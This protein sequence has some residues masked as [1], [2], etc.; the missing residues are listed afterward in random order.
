[1][2]APTRQGKGR[3]ERA[4]VLCTTALT[5]VGLAAA[6]GFPGTAV[7]VAPSTG[8]VAGPPNEEVFVDRLREGGVPAWAI[9]CAAGLLA[10]RDSPWVETG[11]VTRNGRF[12]ST[13][14][15]LIVPN[16]MLKEGW[17]KNAPPPLALGQIVAVDHEWL[18]VVAT[19]LGK[20]T[21]RRAI[22]GT[23]REQHRDNRQL[24]RLTELAALDAEIDLVAGAIIAL[25]EPRGAI[26]LYDMYY[27]DVGSGT[28]PRFRTPA[29]A[30]LKAQAY[31]LL[32]WHLV[33]P[34]PGT[35]LPGT[36]TS[37]VTLFD[38]AGLNLARAKFTLEG[39][40]DDLFKGSVPTSGAP[41]RETLG[42]WMT[43]GV[44]KP[45]TLDEVR[46]GSFMRSP[47]P[48]EQALEFARSYLEWQSRISRELGDLVYRATGGAAS[49]RPVPGGASQTALAYYADA[50]ASLYLARLLSPDDK[51]LLAEARVL[52]DRI[53]WSRVGLGFGGSDFFALPPYRLDT[54]FTMA[55][56][57][58]TSVVNM[59][60]EEEKGNARDMAKQETW[61]TELV[62]AKNTQQQLEN[63]FRAQ[64]RRQLTASVVEIEAKLSEI[65]TEET[66]FEYMRARDEVR[67]QIE[68]GQLSLQG[69]QYRG[70]LDRLHAQRLA[71]FLAMLQ[72]LERHGIPSGVLETGK[73]S[74]PLPA[75]L[76]ELGTFANGIS[77]DFVSKTAQAIRNEWQSVLALRNKPIGDQSTT[78]ALRHLECKAAEM[79]AGR[80]RDRLLVFDSKARLPELIAQQDAL[81]TR[82]DKL[83]NELSSVWRDLD[84][85]KRGDVEKAVEL[86]RR[87]QIIPRLKSQ[88]KEFTGRLHQ[89][90]DKV[91][92]IQNRLQQVRKTVED[93]KEARKKVEDAY[94]EVVGIVKAAKAIPVTV[95]AGMTT[96][97]FF[98]TGEAIAKGTQAVLD[99][100]VAGFQ[101]VDLAL[102]L[103]QAIDHAADEVDKYLKK[104]E[105]V[106]TQL[107]KAQA[108][109]EN[110]STV[111]DAIRP[112]DPG[113]PQYNETL[114]KEREL[115][116]NLERLNAKLANL[117]SEIAS[118]KVVI[119]T[120]ERRDLEAWSDRA[121][122]LARAAL[123][124]FEMTRVESDHRV[125][126]LLAQAEKI[127][128]INE[129]RSN[130]EA[131]IAFYQK[132]VDVASLRLKSAIRSI[133]K[134]DA[135]RKEA[136]LAL[137]LRLVSFRAELDELARPRSRVVTGELIRSLAPALALADTR[138][139]PGDI[140]RM[141]DRGNKLALQCARWL[142]VFGGDPESILLG[143]PARSPAEL[144]LMTEDLRSRWDR[145]TGYYRRSPTLFELKLDTDHL[146]QLGD[147]VVIRVVVAPGVREVGEADPFVAGKKSPVLIRRFA[148]STIDRGI[149]TF[150]VAG[151]DWD[152]A[153]LLGFWVLHRG[154]VNL[155]PVIAP[156]GPIRRR[157]PGGAAL[158]F[159]IKP[160][161]VVVFNP[162]A[163]ADLYNGKNVQDY[164]EKNQQLPPGRNFLADP[165]PAWQPA[166]PNSHFFGHGI[167]GLWAMQVEGTQ[168]GDALPL[169]QLGEARLVFA[170]L[171]PNAQPRTPNNAGE[172][173]PPAPDLSFLHRSPAAVAATEDRD[174]AFFKDDWVHSPAARSARLRD[175]AALLD[176]DLKNDPAE[177]AIPEPPG[178]SE[179]ARAFEAELDA[180]FKSVRREAGKGPDKI[181][182]IL[183]PLP[184]AEQIAQA[185]TLL[186]RLTAALERDY[187]SRVVTAARVLTRASARVEQVEAFTQDLVIQNDRFASL[188][189]YADGLA[190]LARAVDGR[191]PHDDPSVADLR[192]MADDNRWRARLAGALAKEL[193]GEKDGRSVI[194]IDVL[195]HLTRRSVSPRTEAS[196]MPPASPTPATPRP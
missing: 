64:A 127:R 140:Q 39:V 83:S 186:D 171:P 172:L 150:Q 41:G 63:A 65:T 54:Y 38:A 51:A 174:R 126:L 135:K 145:L 131:L 112:Y 175:L 60:R 22:G 168:A 49:T 139:K 68:R 161:P 110:E 43:R 24:R 55:L 162:K 18:E 189:R 121:N 61:L 26:T 91:R 156:V 75:T 2:G 176:D 95:T 30:L 132:S 16:E 67:E 134:D 160:D 185:S 57:E 69:T 72:D 178:E 56:M 119:T 106:E 115:N 71:E 13:A 192:A 25:G 92:D 27:N 62:N 104:A 138:P 165:F 34:P 141:L 133:D 182:T 96:G 120:A 147:R 17:T 163:E 180:V 74:A 102:K 108:D 116:A 3:A 170:I 144:K 77:S 53:A 87:R 88:I 47:L 183:L 36:V 173:P 184:V 153:A 89:A 8:E 196:P 73:P 142:Y 5:L 70:E 188:A 66:R 97:T 107:R 113:G 193:R 125:A 14:D 6:I 195:E 164:L 100:I 99:N 190:R 78:L 15:P 85:R 154:G 117:N 4:S 50:R 136:D 128:R 111:A 79:E 149:A 148:P 155:Y 152:S 122:A 76:S 157:P 103:D 35:T 12:A 166:P 129:E 191:I 151:P 46:R 181:G 84:Q 94:E 194:L 23:T 19:D 90:V 167:G 101:G 29:A 169:S 31:R 86:A 40:A 179:Y 11:L 48:A 118:E 45:M 124:R 98:D 123:A 109:L 158:M 143:N 130:A 137:R 32:A 44:P 7:A 9:D 33:D 146:K 10:A 159:P 82:V 37:P 93:I 80:E 114:E 187:T 105:D 81:T 42:V 20:S 52:A 1:M 177:I 59:I 21:F 28:T 58:L